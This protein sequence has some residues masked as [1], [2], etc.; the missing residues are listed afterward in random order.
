MWSYAVTMTGVLKKDEDFSRSRNEG[1]QSKEREI[2]CAKVLIIIYL[3]PTITWLWD[4]GLL[5]GKL[6]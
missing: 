6:F 3:V 1:S 2:I 5:R 4:P